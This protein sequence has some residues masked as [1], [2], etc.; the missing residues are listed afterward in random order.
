MPYVVHL[1]NAALS[2]CVSEYIYLRCCFYRCIGFC[3]Y[4]VGVKYIHRQISITL[5]Y[6][7]S[8]HIGFK[9]TDLC[10][11]LLFITIS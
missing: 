3:I 6:A 9:E 11:Y 5:P 10:V 4:Q 7:A 2:I 8:K 1:L